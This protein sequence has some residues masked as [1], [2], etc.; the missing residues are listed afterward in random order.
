MSNENE[1]NNYRSHSLDK[2]LFCY[3]RIMIIIV[4][5]YYIYWRNQ[6]KWAFSL[7]TMRENCLRR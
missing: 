3:S 6:Y 2:A 4:N 1:N 5:E 7:K